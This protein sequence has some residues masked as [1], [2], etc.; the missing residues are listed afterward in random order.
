MEK[1]KIIAIVLVIIVGSTFVGG[2]IWWLA[3]HLPQTKVVIGTLQEITTD[4]DKNGGPI[5]LIKIEGRAM[6]ALGGNCNGV[7][8][9]ETIVL[10]YIENYAGTKTIEACEPV[11]NCAG[12]E[13]KEVTK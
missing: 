13:E 5:T 8:A 7:N 11:K 3:T 4:T 10:V 1:K 9:N 12:S 6:M 2:G